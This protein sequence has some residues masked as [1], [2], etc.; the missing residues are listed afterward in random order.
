MTE[1]AV[2]P[3][4]KARSANAAGRFD[5]YVGVHKGLRSFMAETLASVGRMDVHDADDV[6]RTL[7]QV[8]E[9]LD[10]CRH[11][12]NAEDRFIHAAMEARR[13]GSTADRASEHADHARAFER[14]EAEVRAVERVQP[15]ARAAAAL[16]LYR[17]LAVFVAENLEHMHAEETA[18]NAV[19][20]ATHSDEEIAELQHAIVASIRPETMAVF[21]RW[22]IPAMTPAERAGLLGGIQLGAPREVLER[23]L[24]T[25]RPHLSERDWT[26]L[27]AAIAPLPV[28][29]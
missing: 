9:L 19:L 12:L 15:E 18:H 3:R 1:I 2:K 4:T 21:T 16:R 27:I 17:S 26:K 11:H 10:V 29:A 24:A 25:V 5:I 20:W 8:R 14:L 6:G 22:M 13:P 7:A 28:F 23:I